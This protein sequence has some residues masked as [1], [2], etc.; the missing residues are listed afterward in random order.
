MAEDGSTMK[1]TRA[2]II[3]K[4]DGTKL[5]K[6]IEGTSRGEVNEILKFYPKTN[7]YKVSFLLPDGS[8]VYDT[9]PVSY[10]RQNNPTSMSEIEKEFFRI[11]K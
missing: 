3:R 2:H 5:A 10:L 6:T 9:I 11:P 7:K 1:K 4:S 8:L